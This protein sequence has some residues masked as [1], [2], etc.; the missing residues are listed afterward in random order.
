MPGV[1]NED[2]WHRQGKSEKS[3]H[4]DTPKTPKE[5]LPILSD[6][7]GSERVEVK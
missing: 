4:K 5:V 7:T 1:E 2:W 3:V 6:K